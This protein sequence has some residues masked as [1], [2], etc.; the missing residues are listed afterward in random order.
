MGHRHCERREIV[1]SAELKNFDRPE[2]FLVIVSGTGSNSRAILD[3]AMKFVPARYLLGLLS[4]LLAYGGV[5]H[6]DATRTLNFMKPF[7]V[8]GTFAA[9]SGGSALSR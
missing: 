8:F 2:F 4:A 6:A 3:R 7:S 5:S 9:A 1:F